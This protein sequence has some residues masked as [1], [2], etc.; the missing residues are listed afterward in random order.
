MS[1]ENRP[2]AVEGIDTGGT[3]GG[4]G[5]DSRESHEPPRITRLGTVAELTLG[6]PEAGRTDGSFPGSL[7]T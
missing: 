4:D 1:Y 7:F 3:Y 5:H 2:L 6:H